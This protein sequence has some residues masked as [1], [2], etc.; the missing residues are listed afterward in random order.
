LRMGDR[1]GEFPRALLD[2]SE[3][4]G[5]TPTRDRVIAVA[6]GAV[7]LSLCR[8]GTLA[9]VTEEAWGFTSVSRR[10]CATSPMPDWRLAR[11]H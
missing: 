11:W 4:D 2:P 5:A 7:A 6:I 9:L 3:A 8:A 10:P 1:V